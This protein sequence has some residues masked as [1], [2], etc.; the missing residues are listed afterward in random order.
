MSERSVSAVA[1]DGVPEV[2]P[3]DDLAA[4][5]LAVTDVA[6][7]DIVVVTSKVVSKSEGRL[8]PGVDRDAAIAQESVRVVARRGPTSI[9]S[10]RHGLTMAAAGV[11]NS[12]VAL[13]TLALLPL[14]PDDSARRLR[15]EITARTGVRVAVVITDTAGRPWRQGQTD[16]AIGAAGLT[17]LDDHAGRED[18][19]GN[20]LAVTAPAVADEIAGLAELASSKL[21]NR[22]F[23]VVSG[24][25][26]LVLESG[27]H[28]PG[29][30]ALIR[31][32]TEDLFGFGAREAV[33]RAM[34]GD[35][36][37]QAY[38]GTPAS[39]AEFSAALEQVTGLAAAAHRD[40]H[41]TL[42]GLDSRD[43]RLAPLAFAHGW[44]LEADGHESDT[45]QGIGARF[46]PSTP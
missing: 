43:S 25:G 15:T 39:A 36:T 3:G 6:D 35:Q 9:V 14:D 19:H 16:I 24:L 20:P 11:D 28:G 44:T 18:A 4:L 33:V 5:L 38:F 45:D 7:G 23:V 42:A 1:P 22:P 21:G 27:R 31:P 37:D 10:T 12:N 40:G 13:G 46:R 8:I 41:V 26:D 29:A 32:A 30:R 2:R 17:V 34:A